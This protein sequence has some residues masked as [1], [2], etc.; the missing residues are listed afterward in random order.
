L[1]S[2]NIDILDKNIVILKIVPQTGIELVKEMQKPV[3][4]Y[5]FP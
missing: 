3:S 2:E 4:K 5:L 1:S